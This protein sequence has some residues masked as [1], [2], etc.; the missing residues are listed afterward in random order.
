MKKQQHKLKNKSAA[1][2][3][4]LILTAFAL[5]I[6][7]LVSACLVALIFDINRYNYYIF[8]VVS[9]S[10]AGVASGFITA[11]KKREKGMLYGTLYSLPSNITV[12]LVSATFNSFSIDYDL[13]L[14]F[15]LLVVCSAAGGVLS[16]NIKP[17]KPKIPHRIKK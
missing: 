10:L 12:M 4:T 3:L 6:I 14:T 8:S 2:S 9:L 15:S 1:E 11:R 7:M 13:F 5:Y 17:K 16:V